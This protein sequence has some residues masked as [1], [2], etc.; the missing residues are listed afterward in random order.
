MEA[1][2]SEE[3]FRTWLVATRPRLHRYCARVVGSVVDGEDLVQEVIISALSASAR[4]GSI[5]RPEAWLFRIAHN[6]AR[7]ELGRRAARKE[8]HHEETDIVDNRHNDPAGRLAV[9]ASV[10]SFLG[11]PPAQRAAVVLKD[12]LGYSLEE[13]SDVT[14]AT[15]P[16]VKAALHRGR[17]RLATHAHADS[18]RAD[19]GT[20]A[21]LDRQ[22]LNR[23]VD[24]FNAHDFEAVAHM[25]AN[26]AKLK[27]VNKADLS[28][29]DVVKTYFNN[30][31]T[32]GNWSAL[33]GFVDDYPAVLFFRRGEAGSPTH[34]ALL[35]WHEGKID[36]IR[37]FRYASYVL[38]GAQISLISEPRT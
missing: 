15:I 19:A 12:V 22:L 8:V 16:A 28:G 29:E 27:L 20:G 2:R 36:R 4:F 17:N 26:D 14:S 38:D 10:R 23:Y 24:R 7:K 1:L 35:D 3:E 11:L 18:W 31:R 25:L 6:A 5:E 33:A 30:Y 34:F 32:T 9:K 21:E 37:D 13:I